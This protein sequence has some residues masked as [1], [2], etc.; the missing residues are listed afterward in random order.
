VCWKVPVSWG[1]ENPFQGVLYTFADAE[2]GN[3]LKRIYRVADKAKYHLHNSV[4][5]SSCKLGTVKG[6]VQFLGVEFAY[7]PRPDVKVIQSLSLRLEHGSEA[8]LEGPSVAG[9]STIGAL[10]SRLYAPQARTIFLDGTDISTL[11]REW[12]SAQVVAVHQGPV[13]IPGSV[14]EAIAYGAPDRPHPVP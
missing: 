3:T 11:D 12:Y 5:D 6:D 14:R 7:P 2:A 9:K 10:L 4:L 1:L 13:L 8:A